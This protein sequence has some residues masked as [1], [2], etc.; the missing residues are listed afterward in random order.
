MF[1]D[2][3]NLHYTHEVKVAA[4]KYHIRLLF[5]S[6]YSSEFNPIERLWA[7]SK[8]DFARTAVLSGAYHNQKQMHDLVRTCILRTSNTAI[9]VHTLNCL[10]Q[11]KQWLDENAGA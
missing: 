5:N 3:L 4:E 6:A 10:A 7:W 9:K 8:K 11:M 1:L 2:N